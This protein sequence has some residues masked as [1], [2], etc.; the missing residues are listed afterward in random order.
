MN[1]Y[2]TPASVPDIRAD[3]PALLDPINQVA[4]FAVEKVNTITVADRIGYLGKPGSRV[5]P[6]PDQWPAKLN[7]R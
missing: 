2:R 5:H 6:L 4:E 3:H 7:A 1:P